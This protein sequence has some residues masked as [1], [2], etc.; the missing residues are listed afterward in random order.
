ML[1]SS[2]S[3]ELLLPPV[4]WRSRAR[5]GAVHSIRSGLRVLARFSHLRPTNG[6]VTSLAHSMK[7]S[8]TGL[9]VRFLRRTIATGH[10]VTGKSTGRILRKLKRTHEAGKAVMYSSLA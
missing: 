3:W 7:R 9:R 4:P 8:T 2:E 1:G 6:F 10:G 5:G